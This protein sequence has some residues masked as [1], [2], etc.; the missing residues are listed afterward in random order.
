MS[1]KEICYFTNVQQ[2]VTKVIIPPPGTPSNAFYDMLNHSCPNFLITLKVWA[3]DE[4]KVRQTHRVKRTRSKI[5]GKI[6]TFATVVILRCFNLT[7]NLF[8]SFNVEKQKI[9]SLLIYKSWIEININKITQVINNFYSDFVFS[10]TLSLM[11]LE[12]LLWFLNIFWQLLQLY[13]F[14][15]LEYGGCLSLDGNWHPGL[16]LL[17]SRWCFSCIGCWNWAEHPHIIAF[18]FHG[19]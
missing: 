14:S 3:R 5:W 18:V 17:P 11:C 16:D 6:L 15:T 19:Y 8:L 9:D 13:P 7:Q 1:S 10:Q 4:H 12:M 2:N